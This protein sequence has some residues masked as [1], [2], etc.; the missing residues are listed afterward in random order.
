MRRWVFAALLSCVPASEEAPAAGAAGVHTT[1]TA[2]ARGDVFVTDD[3]WSVCVDDLVFRAYLS[4]IPVDSPDLYGGG[5]DPYLWNARDEVDLYASALSLG[6]WTTRLSLQPAY[7]S[8]NS[9]ERVVDLGVDPRY[10]Q[11]FREPP[12]VYTNPYGRGFVAG[13]LGLIVAHGERDGR[14]VS[15]DV[16]VST[17]SY[18]G[19]G[20]GPFPTVLVTK[21]A[22]AT[23][24]L[25]ID[26][27]LLFVDEAGGGAHFQPIADADTDHD[28]IATPDELDALRVACALCVSSDGNRDGTGALLDVLALRLVAVIGGR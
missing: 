1:P 3:G 17:D 24:P 14:K 7:L 10:A 22:L 8:F 13:P 21:N 2:A 15:I 4:A 18:S 6:T 19:Y 20:P 23:A 26:A 28:G 9:N 27:R 12:P 11:R 5:S 16:A 25:V